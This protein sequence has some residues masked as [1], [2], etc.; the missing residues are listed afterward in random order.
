MD[1]TEETII[2]NLYWP[3]IINAVH[4]EVSNCD[5]CQHTKLSNKKYGQLPANLDEQ[6]LWNKLCVYLIGT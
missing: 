1:R 6:I 4:R 3:G 5:T 2:Q